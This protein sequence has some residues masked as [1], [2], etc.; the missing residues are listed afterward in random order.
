MTSTLLL[1]LVEVISKKK[2]VEMIHY[3]DMRQSDGRNNDQ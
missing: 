2:L 3:K 1:L